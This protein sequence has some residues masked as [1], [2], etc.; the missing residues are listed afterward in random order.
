MEFL[1]GKS[2]RSNS[3]FK[4]RRFSDLFTTLGYLFIRSVFVVSAFVSFPPLASVNVCKCS[5]DWKIYCRC[6]I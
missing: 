1:A 6:V 3:D 4:L 5:L 2:K